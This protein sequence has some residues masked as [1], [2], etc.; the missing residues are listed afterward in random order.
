[1]TVRNLILRDLL[2][3]QSTVSAF[4]QRYGLDAA[5]VRTACD[6]LELDLLVESSDISKTI[7][8]F[9]L[10]RAGRDHAAG[11]QTKSTTSP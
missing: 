11:I 9:R 5:E 7:T 4:A 1:M 3:G 6:D 2:N 8:V 10:T